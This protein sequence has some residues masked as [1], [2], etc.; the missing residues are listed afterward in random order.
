[1]KTPR[2]NRGSRI[3]SIRQ[4]L[5]ESGDGLTTYELEEKTQTDRSH[6]SRILNNMPDAYIDRW[7]SAN[8]KRWVRAVWCVVVPPEN[9]PRPVFKTTKEKEK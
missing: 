6:I 7:I 2:R 8:G 5:R 4:A 1:M 9:C 3:A